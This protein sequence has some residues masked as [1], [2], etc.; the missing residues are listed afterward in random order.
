VN[1]CHQ[2]KSAQGSTKT[3]LSSEWFRI[4]V[5]RKASALYAALV[6]EQVLVEIE[7]RCNGS[8]D[9]PSMVSLDENYLIEIRTHI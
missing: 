6:A 3:Q 2:S 5:W 1:F 7:K 9:G 8:Y 4:G